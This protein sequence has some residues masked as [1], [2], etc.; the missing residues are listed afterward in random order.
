V[1]G[2]AARDRYVLV[3]LGWDDMAAMDGR[4]SRVEI[5]V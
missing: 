5:S 1:V 3:R 4:N 2:S